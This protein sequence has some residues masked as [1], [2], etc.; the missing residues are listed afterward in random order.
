MPLGKN[1][2]LHPSPQSRILLSP[3]L[4]TY[5]YYFVRSMYVHTYSSASIP[6]SLSSTWAWTQTTWP[7]IPSHGHPVSGYYTEDAGQGPLHTG[8]SPFRD[9][10]RPRF[11]N[12]TEWLRNQRS[13][14]RRH[15]SQAALA[16]A[17]CTWPGC[18]GLFSTNN[19]KQRI[20]TG[21]QCFSVP[22]FRN[23]TPASAAVI[24]SR[25]P[26][27]PRRRRLLNTRDVQSEHG[28]CTG[29]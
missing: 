24:S 23:G 14:R 28:Y 25:Y 22:C 16:I 27:L 4:Y 2:T 5:L 6:Q 18:H 10:T 15:P 1:T 20:P 26:S 21:V 8:S 17:G 3:P 7:V 9:A 13:S 19:P 29:T 12:R 11:S